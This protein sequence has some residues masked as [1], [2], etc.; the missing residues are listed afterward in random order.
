MGQTNGCCHKEVA[1]SAEAVW[2]D[3]TTNIFPRSDGFDLDTAMT[4]TVSPSKPRLERMPTRLDLEADLLRGI[5]LKKTLQ[6]PR[7]LWWQSPVDMTGCKRA[8]LWKRSR[9]VTGIDIF[10]SH[11]W[12]TSGLSKFLSLL[13]Q[14]CWPI[15]LLTWL[16]ATL[17]LVFLSQSL[18]LPGRYLH[19]VPAVGYPVGPWITMISLPASVF[20]FLLAIYWPE[21]KSCWSSSPMCFLD[22]VSINQADEHMMQRG[23]YGLG[24]FLKASKELR[25]LWSPLYFERL[26]CI[27][28]LAAYRT[29]NP[30]G[31]ITLI[32]L[33]METAVSIYFVAGYVNVLVV[34][35]ILSVEGLES[36]QVLSFSLQ[37]F[38]A[39][40]MVYFLRRSIMVKR[41]LVSDLENFDL[42]LAKC[43]LE[44]DRDFVC[45]AIV[46]W[47]GSKKAFTDYV[48]VHLRKAVLSK[49]SQTVIPLE[50]L[51]LL[52][53][54]DMALNLDNFVALWIGGARPEVLVSHFLAMLLGGAL[55]WKTMNL[56]LT[57]YL[58]DIIKPRSGL[59]NCGVTFL[60]FAVYNILVVMG[61]FISRA[62]YYRGPAGAI[63]WF[64]VAL[65]LLIVSQGGLKFF[66]SRSTRKMET[67]TKAVS[68]E[69]VIQ[70]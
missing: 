70:I 39:F 20:G 56:T 28:E 54:P 1:P 51:L 49:L 67:E 12:L 38:L 35:V 47:F 42:D 13:L 9:P 59:R 31:K 62:A 19:G 58:C 17:L 21:G 43:R 41:R 45:N 52:A 63:L 33:F 61:I 14:S 22:A 23:V 65:T 24:G 68:E 34:W 2:A 4:E 16:L 53:T 5:P 3:T 69:D 46:E 57:V 37:S 11:T 36:Y 27:F 66:R 50:Y 32:P 64:F 25:I 18:P 30:D 55:C 15:A 10:L 60:I 7:D 29:A 8:A 6:N 48:Q 26:W 40:V 44:Y